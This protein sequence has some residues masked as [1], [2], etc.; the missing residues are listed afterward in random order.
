VSRRRISTCNEP[1]CPELTLEPYCDEHRRAQQRDE[2]ARY[3]RQQYGAE[4]D[5]I[6]RRQ[7]RRQ[8]TCQCA[9][10][11]CRCAGHCTATAA[12]VDHVVGLR[13]FTTRAVAH[14]DGNLQ[15][16]CKPCHSRKTAQ[17]VLHR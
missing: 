6:R 15:S 14:Q 16:L 7:L 5:R 1:D 9:D 10:P 4:W 11:G 17:E 13:H 2:R 12:E 8:P 3:P